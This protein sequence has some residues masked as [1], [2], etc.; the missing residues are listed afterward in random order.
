[1]GVLNEKRC[2]QKMFSN[3]GIESSVNYI[4]EEL[5]FSELKNKYNGK[6]AYEV[7]NSIFC[8]RKNIEVYCKDWE[9]HLPELLTDTTNYLTHCDKHLISQFPLWIKYILLELGIMNKGLLQID[10]TTRNV[11]SKM[12]KKKIKYI[13]KYIGFEPC[14]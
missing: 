5:F 10:L 11:R 4:I 8:H 1:M 13:E 7:I 6:Y 2:K 14:I 3:W 12:I 9:T